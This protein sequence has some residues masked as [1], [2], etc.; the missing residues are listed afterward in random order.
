MWTFEANYNQVEKVSHSGCVPGRSPLSST[1]I[2]KG[3]ALRGTLDLDNGV[4]CEQIETT[5]TSSE[6]NETGVD[7]G[8]YPVGEVIMRELGWWDKQTVRRHLGA[9]IGVVH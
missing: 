7:V 8:R 2:L 1:I 3:P 6:Y 5:R 4:A 9:G